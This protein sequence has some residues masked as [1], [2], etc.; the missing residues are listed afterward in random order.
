M[1]ENLFIPFGL[2]LLK[3]LVVLFFIVFLLGILL[4]PSLKKRQDT[5]L[6]K[7]KIRKWQSQQKSLQKDLFNKI[8]SAKDFKKWKKQLS[9]SQKKDNKKSASVRKKRIYILDFKGDIKASRTKQLKKEIS[10]LTEVLTSKDE[11]LLRIQSG[12]GSVIGYGQAAAEL[13][14]LRVANFKLTVAIDQIAA[15]GGYLM[16][17]VANTI[18]AAPFSIV[19]SIGVIAMAPNFHDL[20]K[21]KD[22]DFT[23]YTAGKYKNTI[24]LFGENTKKGADKFNEYLA[25]THQLFQNF[26]LKYRPSIDAKSATTGEWWHAEDALKLNLVDKILTSEQ[27]LSTQGKNVDIFE[28]SY[29]EKIPFYNQ[30]S[31]GV[32]HMLKSIKSEASHQDIGD[33]LRS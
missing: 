22:I 17:C 21:K 27:Y 15:S 10:L 5:L 24:S 2:F 29:Q 16:A 30:A 31:N 11:V 14:R 18:I 12:G 6:G 3:T 13:A 23:I 26:I 9:L 1:I 33:Q 28:I 25:N 20:L 4:I 19:G 7:L 8:L 32:L